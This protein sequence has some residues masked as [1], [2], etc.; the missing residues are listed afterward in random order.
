MSKKGKRR[1][2]EK[3]VT[4]LLTPPV[5]LRASQDVLDRL[6]MLWTYLRLRDEDGVRRFHKLES[7]KERSGAAR[8]YGSPTTEE[9]WRDVAAELAAR[10]ETDDDALFELI[11]RD[12]RYLASE[13]VIARILEWRIRVVLSR[14]ARGSTEARAERPK[15]SAKHLAKLKA[16][17]AAIRSSGR[18]GSSSHVSS[19][20]LAS[21]EAYVRQQVDQGVRLLKSE[22]R[23]DETELARR[24]GLEGY[25]AEL[26]ELVAKP[27][28]PAA[29]VREILKAWFGTA[30]IEQHR[31]LAR[32]LAVE[33]RR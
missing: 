18:S 3:R 20:D 21:A 32:R 6:S 10:A 15:V 31:V 30:S 26:S 9:E 27:D 23:L 11:E 29:V 2:A 7:K 8:D 14:Y 4:N 13:L 28:A 25:A 22:E 1:P 12:P 5:E 16:V 24:I 17:G 19:K 33:P